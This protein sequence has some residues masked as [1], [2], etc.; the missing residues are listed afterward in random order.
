MMKHKT[1]F[2]AIGIA[3]LPFILNAQ[4]RFRA[5]IIAGV[6]ASQINGDNSAGYNK[7][8]LVAG[9]RVVSRIGERTD[10]SIELLFAQRGAQSEL[11]RDNFNPN[12]FALTLNYIEVPV[13]WHYKDWLIEGD[14]ESEDYYRVA[15]DLG[16]SYARFFSSRFRGEPNGI[17]VVSKDYL[18]KNDISLVLGANVFFTQHLGITLRYVRSLGAMYNPKDWNPAPIANS[19]IGHCLYLQGVYLF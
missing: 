13:Q 4:Q 6:T 10:G 5:G 12:N 17:E 9:F 3:L 8:G 7:P 18:K 14:N 15:F 1:L 11:V 19:W 16:L 2:F